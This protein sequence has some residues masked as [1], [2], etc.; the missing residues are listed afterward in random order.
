MTEGLFSR[1]KRFIGFTAEDERRVRSLAPILNPVIDEVVERFY[2]EIR[3]DDPAKAL[4]GGSEA[5]MNAQEAVLRRWLAEL[6]EGPYDE[7][8]Y[9]RARSAGQTHVRIGMP[10]HY[11]FTAMDVIRQEMDRLLGEAGLPTPD[12][13]VGSLHK[14]LML[15]LAMMMESYQTDFADRVRATERSA[16]ERKLTRSEHLA[17]IGRLAASLAHEIK[18]P[19]AGISGA[20]QIIGASMDRDNPH[21][22]IIAEILGQIRRLDAAVKD[23]LVYAR[24]APLNVTEVELGKVIRGVLT[25][26]R[27]EPSLQDRPVRCDL[28]AEGLRLF[29]DE[30]QMRQLLMNLLINAADASPAGG[31]VRVSAAERG[32]RVWITVRDDGHGMSTEALDRAFE[33]FFTTKAKGTGLGL[34][35][36]K[37]IVEMHRGDMAIESKVGHGTTVTVD[38]PVGGEDAEE[39][40]PT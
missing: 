27:E 32:G 29:A 37:R 20:I 28:P 19:L 16:F 38:L 36:C 33:P 4:F 31:A 11:M 2:G 18:N 39:A 7:A 14:L 24:P 26:L 8:H 13:R 3:R 12:P 9:D 1:M 30:S 10:Q 15:E 23:L 5:R 6:L 17:E 21:V 35:I 34:S 40:T 22:P 25:I